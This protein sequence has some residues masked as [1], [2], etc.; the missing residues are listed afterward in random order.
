MSKTLKPEPKTVQNSGDRPGRSKKIPTTKPSRRNWLGILFYITFCVFALAVGTVGGWLMSSSVI[1]KVGLSYMLH[2][3]LPQVRFGTGSMNVL[4]LGC[5]V[6]ESTGGAKITKNGARSDTMLLVHF[7]FLTGQISGISIPRDVLLKMPGMPIH[8]MNAFHEFGGD[9]LAA[10][11]VEYLLPGVHVDRTV[12][13]NYNGFVDMVNAVGGV[14]FYVPKNMNW[15]DNAGHLH[16]HL[17][18]GMQVLNGKHAEEMV[19][20]RHTDSDIVRQERQHEFILAFQRKL[21]GNPQA[22]TS[23]L[24]A[25]VKLLADGFS[26]KDTISLGA[27]I[28][29]LKNKNIEL[30]MLPTRNDGMALKVIRSKIEPTLQKYGF[31]SKST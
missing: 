4:V 3:P 11:A 9:S 31:L 19:R 20:F 8:K 6:D 12:A 24:D 25:T 17:K 1:S 30:G 23:V 22:L 21:E 5:D 14:P 28:A 27:W 29:G 15:D 18:K 2:P 26:A 7:N 16:I 10:K 13:I